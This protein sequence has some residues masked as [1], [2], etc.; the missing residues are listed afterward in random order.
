MKHCANPGCAYRQRHGSAAEFQDTIA[1]CTDCGAALVDGSAP[2]PVKVA[3]PAGPAPWSRL[4][5]SLGFGLLCIVGLFVP[6]PGTSELAQLVR[7]GGLLGLF[8]VR[9]PPTLS[10]LAIGLIPIISAY[11]LVEV[12]VVLVPS[13]RTLRISG[14]AGRAKLRPYANGLTG[15]LAFVQAAG[16]AQYLRSMGH[17]SVSVSVFGEND[18]ARWTPWAAMI[19]SPARDARARPHHRRHRSW[20]LGDGFSVV[21]VALMF[22]AFLSLDVFGNFELVEIVILLVIVG[23]MIWASGR[24]LER[25]WPFTSPSEP[26]AFELPPSGLVPLTTASQILGVFMSAATLTGLSGLDLGHGLS[27][28]AMIL[29]MLIVASL[30]VG[31]ALLFNP[32]RRVAELWFG[33]N[34][35][36]AS[37]GLVRTQLAK[38]A[39]RGTVFVVT[40]ALLHDA[41][42]AVFRLTIVVD[43]VPVVTLTA[44]L[45]DVTNEFHFRRSHPE[46]V[47]IWPMHRVYAVQPVLA[48]LKDAGIPVVVRALHHRTLLQFFGPYLPMTILVPPAHADAARTLVGQRLTS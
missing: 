41:L 32:P 9:G 12:V 14:E 19:D 1:T 21:F 33:R 42:P 5:V 16:I 34:P 27:G 2:T 46:L 37:T 4:G 39:I 15:L 35:S 26:F 3:T 36:E 11:Q 38:A 13:W 40:L 23:G 8:N 47:A 29:E 20:G 22:P 28:S 48:A 24:A 31:F 25:R 44:V 7:S 6:L 43:L 45:L 30:G 10:V 17:M 18:L